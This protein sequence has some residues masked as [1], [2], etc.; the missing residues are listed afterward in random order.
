MG[1]GLV[2]ILIVSQ[3]FWPE[4]FRIND[5][6]LGLRERGHAVSVLTGL[7]NYPS[8]EFFAGYGLKGPWSDSMDGI[9]ITRVPLLRRGSAKGWMLGLNFVSFAAM[10]SLIGPARVTGDVDV[11]FVYEPSPITVALPAIVLRKL[12][13]VPMV[14]WVQDLWPDV[15]QVT[16]AI[17]SPRMLGHISRLTRWIYRHCDKILAESLAFIPAIQAKGVPAE[18]LDYMPN[19]A[20]AFYKPLCLEADAPERSEMPQG[21]RILFAGNIGESQALGVVLSA[22]DKLRDKGH[23]HWVFIGDGR[24]HDWLQAEVKRR[25]LNEVVHILGR[26]PVESMPRYFAA[27]D[28]LLVTLRADPHYSWTVPSKL[29][30]YMACG[31]PILGAIEGEGARIILESGG[32]LVAGAENPE[33]L[34]EAALAFVSMPREDRNAMGIN[35]RKYFEEHFERETIIDRLEQVLIR[36]AGGDQ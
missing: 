16:A 3:Y 6:S 4:S 17:R 11:I 13:S 28:A 2:R 33:S 32:G 29:Q 18:R 35:A 27:A 24:K 19:W 5:L 22:A 7:P 1:G 31:K 36:V 12:R 30:S 15:L 14:L 26:R 25:G 20:E 8:G 10:A 34:A 23:I 21:F 9:P